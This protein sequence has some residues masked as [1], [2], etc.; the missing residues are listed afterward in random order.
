MRIS[1]CSVVVVVVVV[2]VIVVVVGSDAGPQLAIKQG[3]R[4]EDGARFWC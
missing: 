2:V 3:A 4:S 1:V